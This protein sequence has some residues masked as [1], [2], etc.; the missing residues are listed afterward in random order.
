[1]RLLAALAA[2]GLAARSVLTLHASPY[3]HLRVVGWDVRE[4][5]A[6]VRTSLPVIGTAHAAQCET[7]ELLIRVG[8]HVSL[9]LV[10]SDGSFAAVRGTHKRVDVDL[11]IADL[12]HAVVVEAGAAVAV[13]DGLAGERDHALET[14]VAL[15]ADVARV[16]PLLQTAL[17]LLLLLPQELPRALFLVA[18]TLLCAV[19]LLRMQTQGQRQTR[20]P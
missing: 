18:A 19:L 16:P 11:R 14:H 1:M 7:L 13:S 3:I 20:L 15:H 9:E 8:R 6:A 10:W 12:G 5:V 4:P 17:P 2:E